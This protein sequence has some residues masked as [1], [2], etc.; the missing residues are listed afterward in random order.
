VHAAGEEIVQASVAA[1]G[2]LSGEHGIGMEKR[3]LMPLMFAPADLAA[4]AA[5]RASFD[6]TGLANPAKVL[7]SP[8]ACGDAHEVPEGL[9]V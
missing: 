4:Q 7:P 9:W 1:G 6:T 5:L 3:D 2:V 8:A